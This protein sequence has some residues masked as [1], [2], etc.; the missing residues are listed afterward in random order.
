[1][2]ETASVIDWFAVGRGALWIMGLA[3][4]LAAFSYVEWWRIR[5]RWRLRR[6]LNTPRFLLPF[7][8]GMSLFCIGLGLSSQQWWGLGAGLILAALFLVQAWAHWRAGSLHGWD[9]PITPPSRTRHAED[10]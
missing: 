7:S 10:S 6:A 2:N 5:H 8:V 4:I 9:E 1:M 3:I